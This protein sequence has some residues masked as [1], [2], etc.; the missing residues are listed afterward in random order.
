MLEDGGLYLLYDVV[1][2][3]VCHPRACRKADADFEEGFGY[4]VDVGRGVFV[5]G[6]AVH[7]F[8]QGARLDAG[9]V[10]GHAQGLDVVVGLAVGGG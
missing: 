3:V 7:R 8:P 2:M 4:A 6:L 5:D 1:D 10:E 9:R